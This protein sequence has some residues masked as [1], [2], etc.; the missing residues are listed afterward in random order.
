M[1]RRLSA[2]AL[3][4][5]LAAACLLML[6]AAP[7]AAQGW[8]ARGSVDVGATMFSASQSF[9][10]ILGT[11]RGTVFGGGGEVVTPQRIFAGVRLSRFQKDGQRVFV[12]EDETF[13]LGI[14]TQIRVTPIEVTG[15]Y[16]FREVARRI[17][18]YA[19]AGLSWHRLQETS[20]F[21]AES[22]NVDETTRGFHVLGGAEFRLARY[23]GVGGE[24]Q[25][26]TVPDGLGS[27]PNSVAA[28]FGE[29]DLGGTSIR[30]KIVIGR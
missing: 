26:T 10:A 3:P 14:D 30:L 4:R 11:A 22:E 16:R 12:F 6:P 8:S 2:H 1:S 21:A 7:A 9:D 5:C 28:A 20:D 18:P 19:G 29:S 25:W 23:V 13:D 15:G 17:V 24:L 27:D